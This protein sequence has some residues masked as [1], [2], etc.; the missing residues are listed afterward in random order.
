[1]RLC[2]DLARELFDWRVTMDYGTTIRVAA[3]AIAAAWWAH[4]PA[5]AAPTADQDKTAIVALEKK[6]NDGFNAKDVDAIMSCYAP[7]NQLFVFDVVP[8]R[9]YPSWE[10]YKKDWE[11]LFA[12]FRGTVTNKISEQTIT[13]VGPVA[14]G[15]NIQTGTFT[16]KDGKQVRI[17]A[18]TTD[19]YRKL[20]G[21]WFIVEEHNSIPVDLTSMTPDPLSK[22]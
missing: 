14:Y 10:A 7:G 3:F 11:G 18:R 13:V 21:A 1:M 6:Y 9:A 17:V 20:K 5:I 8:P 12:A 22:I 16:G 4:T 15:H 2:F 19:I